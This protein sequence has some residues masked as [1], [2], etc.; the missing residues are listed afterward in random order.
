[1]NADPRYFNDSKQLMKIPFEE[2]IELAYYGA[3]V[4]HPKTIQPLQKKSIPLEVKSFLNPQKESSVI[5]EFDAIDPFIPSVIVK[6]NQ[7]L[8]SVADKNLSF[9]IS[10]I[11]NDSSF[12]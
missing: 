11:L 1:M 5:G 10:Q 12:A 2:A 8:I 4:M 9:I 3:K 7:I 6:E